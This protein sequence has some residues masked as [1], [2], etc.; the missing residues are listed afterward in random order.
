MTTEAAPGR[1]PERGSWWALSRGSA[2]RLQV[3]AAA[4][5]ITEGRMPELFGRL[6]GM[7]GGCCRPTDLFVLVGFFPVSNLCGNSKHIDLTGS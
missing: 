2:L 5:H 1:C 4:L 7:H 6:L 3:P